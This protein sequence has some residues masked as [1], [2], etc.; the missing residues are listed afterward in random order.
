M[1][2]YVVKKILNSDLPNFGFRHCYII[3]F[4]FF[5]NCFW[6][7]LL[8]KLFKF[9]EIHIYNLNEWNLNVINISKI[10]N[11]FRVKYWTLKFSIFCKC[12]FDK[13]CSFCKKTSLLFNVNCKLHRRVVFDRR[14]NSHA[15]STSQSFYRFAKPNPIC[16]NLFPDPFCS[17]QPFLLLELSGTLYRVR[18]FL[19]Y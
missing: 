1:I 6:Q 17:M 18:S 13:T 14:A 11:Y 8:Y 12:C 3:I 16:S 2:L 7:Y 9:I 10:F 5:I 15:L 19:A 4:S